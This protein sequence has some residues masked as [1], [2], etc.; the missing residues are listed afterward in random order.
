MISFTKKIEVYNEHKT[1]FRQRFRIRK[2][3]KFFSVN[4]TK[5]FADFGGIEIKVY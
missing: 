1:V 4:H 2:K 5:L 3:K